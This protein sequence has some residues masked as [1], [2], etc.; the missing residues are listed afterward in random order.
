MSYKKVLPLV[1]LLVF[2]GAGTLL[3][4]LSKPQVESVRAVDIISLTASGF[5]FGTAFGL[6]LM[7]IRPAAGR[8]KGS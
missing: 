1:F 2:V 7:A 3:H 5:S 4:T 8:A 6:L